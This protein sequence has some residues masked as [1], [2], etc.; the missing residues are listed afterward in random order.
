MSVDKI[1]KY[2]IVEAI[3]KGGMGVVYKA[4]DPRIGRVVA[5]KTLFRHSDVEPEMRHRFLQE[6]RS[7]GALS[8]KNIITIYEMDE[9]AGQAFIAMEFLEGEDLRS[10]IARRAPISL[11]RKLQILMEVCEG[12]AHAH[13]AG[14][15]HRDIKPGNIFITRSR[16]VKILDFGLAR[17]ATSD[18]TLTGTSMGTPSYMSPEQVRGEKLDHR[19]DIFS[20][21][22][23]AYELLTCVKPFQAET[24]IATAY[25]VT[26][27]EPD[28]VDKVDPRIPVEIASIVACAMEKDP[29]KRYQQAED[30]YRELESARSLLEER[31]R[32]VREEA[33]AA[34][35]KLAELVRPHRRLVEDVAQALAE[36]QALAPE[37]FDTTLPAQTGELTRRRKGPQPDYLGLLDLRDR[38]RRE[39]DRVVRLVETRKQTAYLV[40][41]VEDLERSGELESALKILEFILR[42][43]PTHPAAVKLKKD[44]TARLEEK[45]LA[46]E[47]TRRL[48][49]LFEQG[50][51]RFAAQDWKGCLE[52]L[53]ALL[54]LEPG[55]A[56]ASALLA[57]A[58]R[59]LR[60]REEAEAQRRLAENALAESRQALS[61]GAL[62]QAR[63]S[64][65]R[66]LAAWPDI[67]G[68]RALRAEIEKAER[69]AEAEAARRRQAAALRSQA[70]ALAKAGNEEEALARLQELLD[71]EPGDP[72]AL[73]LRAGIEAKLARRRRADELVQQAADRLAAD[74]PRRAQ[75]LLLEALELEPDRAQAR[76]FLEEA[77]QK[78][79]QQEA[80]AQARRRAQ[81][82][83]ERARKALAAR[84][85]ETARRGLEEAI[86]ASADVEGAE[87]L[88]AEIERAEAQE[89]EKRERERQIGDLLARA[90]A[91]RDQGSQDEALSL[92]A[93]VLELEPGHRQAL[94]WQKEIEAARRAA[95]AAARKRRGRIAAVIRRARD[96]AQQGDLAA[97]IELARSVAGEA[98]FAEEAEELASAWQAELDRRREI[99]EARRRKVEQLMDSARA[100]LSARALEEARTAL[101]E[102]LA[103]QADHPEVLRLLGQVQAEIDAENARRARIERGEQ[104][105][106]AAFR[107]LQEK[108]YRE[109][110]AAFRRAVELLGEDAGMRAAIAEAE[111]GVR[112][113]ELQARLHA[114][115]VEARRRLLEEAYDAAKAA[116]LRAL[117]LAPE[118]A[119]ARELLG[120]IEAAL[121]QQRTRA[122]IAELLAQARQA[123]GRKDFADASR[124]ANEILLLDSRNTEARELLERIDEAQQAVSRRSEIAALLARSTQAYAAGDF[125]QSAACAREVLLIDPENADARKLLERIEEAQRT[126]QTQERLAALLLQS[127]QERARGELEAALTHAQELLRLEPA[128]REAKALLKEIEKDIRAREK[129]REL[130][131]R[132][133][134]EQQRRQAA[135]A[136]PALRWPWIAA[137]AA[138]IV[139][140]AI[141]AVLQ[142]GRAGAELAVL[143][144]PDGLEI[145]W[146]GRSIGVTSGGKL[147]VRD[148]APGKGTL[149]ARK[150]GF[151]PSAREITLA[152]GANPAVSFRL[153]PQAAELRIRVDQPDVSIQ[154]DGREIGRTAAAGSTSSFQVQEGRHSVRLIKEGF[155]VLQRDPEFS[156]GETIVIY[157]SLRPLAIKAD[158]AVLRILTSPPDAR[159]YLDGKLLGTAAGGSMILQDLKPGPSRLLVRRDGYEDAERNLTLEPGKAVDQI[160]TL[161]PKAAT[162]ILA[163]NVPA[164]DVAVDDAPRGKTDAAGNLTLTGLSPASRTLKVS[165][166]G[167][168]EKLDLLSLKPGETLR[169][170]V[171]LAPAAARPAVLSVS[172]LP[173]KA[174]VYI[175]DEYKGSTPLNDL[176]VEA[177]T[178]RIRIRKDGYR[179]VQ[180]SVDLRAGE[181]RAEPFNLERTRGTLQCNVQPE[182]ALARIGGQTYDLSKQ[183]QIELETGTYTVE[184]TASGY[185]PQQKTITIEDR[186][187]TRLQAVLESAMPALATSYTDAFL[188]LDNWEHPAGWQADNMMRAAGA[189]AAILKGRAYE[190]FRQTF[191]LRLNKGFKASW[192]VRWQDER[193]YCLIQIFSDRSPDRTRRNAIFFSVYR[194]G[195]QAAVYPVPLP[196]PFAGGRSDWIDIQME[197]TGNQIVARGS[198]VS[199]TS[200]AGSELGRYTIQG[201]PARGRVGFA[202]FDDEE[203][204]VSGLVIDPIR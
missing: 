14:V 142:I 143:S 17:A 55:H 19:T 51:A 78:I 58:R 167:Y 160:I 200:T 188:T 124:L 66:A 156:P 50:Q 138:V 54:E 189:G 35:A 6:A 18:Q 194:D 13:A 186:Q 123:A 27:T 119:E 38:A 111:A 73:E 147:A 204:D 202:V 145:L 148:L 97:A 31:K 30:L 108:K 62:E 132:L 181:A 15:I 34:V 176:R 144:E 76:A 1:G 5:I 57:D 22:V 61:A 42:E 146:N 178:R 43:D 153:S 135:A 137:L 131:K 113:E 180:R 191:Q 91:A 172:S 114:E 149:S 102:A 52:S 7:A 85:L 159:I 63:A 3:G 64:L 184:L 11:E 129:E 65:E 87:A 33:R 165:K 88:A 125:Q 103:V 48:A 109:S 21:G 196:F 67:A 161:A 8:H 170:Q 83:I 32:A 203:F 26:H 198:V 150:Q 68:G 4:L 100:L 199:G 96:A 121:E 130:Q 72:A 47:R 59:N 9:D 151:A 174:D 162:L 92:L 71:L 101:K 12:L 197:V 79:A 139:A 90:R 115:L 10:A 126:R 70:Q 155:E 182:G 16:Q 112:E 154:I 116:A 183:K 77:R 192:F 37:F 110:L 128:H 86:E 166:E 158:T 168:Q 106:Q 127:R 2:Q 24:D 177:G 152:K 190:N 122:R 94:E 141:Y 82:A 44:L 39:C 80:R 84:N 45:R 133:A 56:Q 98:E 164:A 81:A 169:L 25:K 46:Q 89:R 134:L 93:R 118:H 49:E 185:K 75:S 20:L 157:E 99:E 175:D 29:A 23:V 187:T 40:S 105:K 74:D 179:E 53:E 136:R 107:L 117:E 69:A 171:T 36:M 104:E 41:E 60:A 140:A 28:P 120:R 193:N 95:E 163:T 201:L 173:D 195:Q